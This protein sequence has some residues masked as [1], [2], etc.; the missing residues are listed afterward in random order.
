M[1]SS[2]NFMPPKKKN[3]IK[4]FIT[5]ISLLDQS[6]SIIFVYGRTTH[7]RLNKLLGHDLECG[8]AKEI[9]PQVDR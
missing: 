6:D 8:K 7:S 2:V 9:F 5:F 3:T 1:V 4:L